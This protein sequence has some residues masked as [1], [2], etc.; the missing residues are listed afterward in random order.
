MFLLAEA[1]S[2]SLP[3]PLMELHQSL[4]K[5]NT[6]GPLPHMWFQTYRKTKMAA[7]GYNWLTTFNLFL[8]RLMEFHQTVLENVI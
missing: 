2:I 1:F 5:A 4:Q 6:Q 7:K 3:Q 8:H